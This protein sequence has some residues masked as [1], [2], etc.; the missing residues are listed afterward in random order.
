MIKRETD[1]VKYLPKWNYRI[2][3]HRRILNS[4]R[5]CTAFDL[6]GI[7][8]NFPGTRQEKQTRI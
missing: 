3:Q 4:P 1:S 7:R 6:D 8:N 5:T 2:I